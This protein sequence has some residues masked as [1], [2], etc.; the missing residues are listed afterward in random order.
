MFPFMQLK[1]LERPSQDA[2]VP[3]LTLGCG[4]VDGSSDAPARGSPPIP[5]NRE[6]FKAAVSKAYPAF[7]PGAVP[8]SA[9]Q[10]YRFVHEMN[11][12]RRPRTQ[13]PRSVIGRRSCHRVSA[14]S[15]VHELET[16]ERDLA[17]LAGEGQVGALAPP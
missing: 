3:H 12:G 11:S 14:H 5:A 10:L 16:R 8:N 6:A 15:R 13:F 4:S 17:V 2:A 9:G 1:L 7:K